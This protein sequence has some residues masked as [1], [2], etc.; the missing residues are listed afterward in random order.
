MEWD[1]FFAIS[2]TPAG[3]ICP[4][5]PEMFRS[6]FA[7]VEAADRLGFGVAWIAE[8]HLSSEVQKR[9]PKPVIPHWQG[10]VGLNVDF[11]QLSHHIFRRTRRIETGSA[12]MNILCN[13]GPIAAAERVA[14]FCALHGLDPD[15]RRRIHVGFAAGRFEFMNRASGIVARDPVEEAAWPA[16]RGKI[17][18]EASEIF[19]RLLRGDTLESGQV[20]TT[21][22]RRG[23]FRSDA[24]WAAVLEAAGRAGASPEEAVLEIPR[25]WRFD[26]LKIIPQDWRRELLQL[27]IGSHEPSLQE[28]A[29]TILPVQ[30][31]NLSITRP[32]IIEETHRRMDAAYHEDGGPWRRS[33]MPRTTFVF[34][35]EQAE[36]S[37]DARR[38]AAQ[39]EARQ[40]LGAYWTALEGTL[41]PRKVAAA[42][43]NALVGNAEDVAAQILE[44]FHPDDR[45][46][47]WFDFFNHDRS[48]VIA[49]MD[50][51]MNKVRPR[52]EERLGR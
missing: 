9:H 39:E 17:F 8:S 38:S 6:F 24:D 46:M 15:E 5:E 14:A 42:A 21:Q 19:L 30:V 44:R 41:D 1:I 43:N 7:Q 51:F 25:R 35:N 28:E 16:L 2:Q 49:N 34:L 37:P 27:V 22:L 40:A 26:A 33:Y 20:R 29:N 31:F 13:G 11:L 23:D 3:G 32:E 10:E 45:L 12:V 47:L 36:L 52:V 48:R 50:D 18:A 4:S